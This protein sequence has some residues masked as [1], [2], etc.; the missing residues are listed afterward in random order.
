MT[1]A[2]Q[3]YPVRTDFLSGGGEMGERIRSFN[4]S[5]TPLKSIEEWPQSL[6]AAAGICVGSGFPIAIYWGPDL[7]LLYNDAWSPIPGEKHPWA[8]GRPAREVWPEIWDT[9]EPLFEQVTQ[10]G[11]ATR[12]RDQLLPMRRHGYTEECYFDYTFTPIHG[13]SGKV[14]GVFNAVLETTDRVIG[15]RRQ[16]TLRELA[17]ATGQAR[18]REAA[19][20]TAARILEDNALDFPFVLIY[21]PVDAADAAK[22]CCAVGMERGTL[23]SP[24][25]VGF[26]PD[27][28][29]PGSPAAQIANVF[30][31]S[32]SQVI[33]VTESMGAPKGSWPEPV[34]QALVLPLS[35]PGHS[36]Y[37]VLVAGISPRRALDA[38]YGGFLDLV[39]GQLT[40]ALVNCEEYEQEKKRAEALAQL[41]RA[42]TAFF[43]NVSHEFRT[44]L[45][46]I[47][48]PLES[49][50]AREA[51]F[52]REDREHV[53]AAH[54]NS[55]RLLKLVNSL[56]DFS[57][58][59]AGRTRASYA[60]VDLAALTAEL[61]ANFRSAMEAAGLKFEVSCEALPE[62]VYVD[63]E[64]WE[65][66][67]FNLLSNAYKFTLNGRVS[68]K[69]AAEGHRAVVTVSD[70]GVGIPNEKLQ[71]VFERFHRIEDSRGRS[72]EGSGIGLALVRDLVELHGGSISVTSELG[73]GA[74]FRVE[75]PFGSAHL[76]QEAVGAI[77]RR[78]GEGI[79]AEAF[80]KEA[81]AWLSPNEEI[82]G[83]GA[84]ATP[85]ERARILVADDNADMR[86]H[87]AR[88]LGSDYEVATVADGSAALKRVRSERPDLLLTDVMM[89]GMDGFELLRALRADPETRTLPV[90]FLSARAGEESRVEGIEAGA[91]DYL[92]KPFTANELRA[93][94]R[95]HVIMN[96]VRLDAESRLRQKDDRLQLALSAG[97]LG[98]WELDTA[99]G[100]MTASDQCK[101][102]FG[103]GP[104]E[105]CN[106]ETLKEAIHPEDRESVLAGMARAIESADSFEAVHRCLWPD[107]SLHWINMRGRAFETKAGRTPLVAGV[108][109]D[110]TEA[111]RTEQELRT[112]NLDLEQFA[113]SASHDLKE[114]LRNIK[115]FAELICSRYESVLDRQGV[116]FLGFVR[117]GAARM[118]MLIRDL[119]AYTQAARVERVK[120][121]VDAGEVLN[122]T[123]ENLAQLIQQSSAVIRAEVM[124]MI[125]VHSTHLQQVFQNLIGNA[126]KYRRK[127][128]TPAIQIGARR[129]H[130]KWLFTIADNGIGI[131]PHYKERIFG[132]FK[133]LHTNDEYEGTGI[134]LALCQRIVEGY[135]G[136]IWVESQPG[137]GSKF[138]FTLP[139]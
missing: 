39:A 41:D 71:H 44:P 109:I 127:D 63:E 76:P 119:L 113:Y 105:Q 104:F 13:E 67:V 28:H 107:G 43:S 9:I 54:R 128:I 5:Q 136:R 126:I 61:A 72:F 123:L 108:T 120:E 65:K 137:E 57:R 81:L 33:P 46:L 125:P 42:K 82:Q 95:T 66:I 96:R 134:G 83:A 133:R 21:I 115:I 91:D 124:P 86:E 34:Q 98:I 6:R 90:I 68:L 47:L 70:T 103:R 25:F 111:K 116:E 80:T 59:E 69:L 4:W 74:E 45:T 48:G 26:A 23:L 112:A 7:V 31:N 50:L 138:H 22:L 11:R 10:T 37:G 16:R 1:P 27:A 139:A 18:S 3:V 102:H 29:A 88:L 8:L 49:L 78:T 35:R 2:E 20:E 93:R 55:L 24:E 64:M 94:V 100:V 99:T 85:A 129:L 114:P 92:V 38:A 131:P 12:S 106:F 60:P 89:P 77:P 56:L 14:E 122:T 101:A 118:E 73:H 32:A 79:R 130:E 135:G 110:I 87:I 51:E 52:S 117:N 97:K 40:Q 17:T 53:S 75:L 121:P 84:A 132:L 36:I 19:C 15:E 58:I 62:S 30:V